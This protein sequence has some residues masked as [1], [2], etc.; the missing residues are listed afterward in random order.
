M[1]TPVLA[2]STAAAPTIPIAVA[3]ALAPD[4][5]NIEIDGRALQVP[6]GSM[7]IQAADKIGVQIPR[8]CYHDK[9]PIA[10]NCRMCLVEVE[11]A[12]KPMPACATPVM[13]G[14]KIHTQSERALSAQRN[15]MEFLLVNHP[16]DCPICDQGG[17]CELQDVAM[18][19]GRSVSRFTEDK[20]VVAD[21][22]LGP[23]I[24]TEMTRC[25]HCTRCVRFMD[26]IAGTNELGGMGRGETL[27]IGTYIGRS[28]RTELSGNII[29]VCPVGAL[30]NKVFRYRAR[31]WELVARA[32][33]G[34]HDS[35][36]SNLYLHTRRGEAMRA[37]PRDN[38]AINESWLSDRDRFSH[39]ALKH[40]ERAEKP[41]VKI[42]G[43]WRDADWAGAIS[44]VKDHLR[45]ITTLHGAD[46]LGVL[47]AGTASAE[48]YLLLNR[49]A[50]GLG[51]NNIDHRLR[52]LDFSDDAARSLAPTLSAPLADIEH[53]RAILLMGCNPRLDAPL[54]GHRV[55]KAWKRGGKVYAINPADFDFHFQVEQKLIGHAQN[56]VGYALA[57][58]KAAAEASAIAAPAE[59]AP[60]LAGALVSDNAR[61][62]VD[63]LKA[64]QPSRILFGEHAAQHPSAAILRACAQFVA[65]ATGAG[66]DEIPDSSNAAAAWRMGAV[67]HRSV[68]GAAIANPGLN[69]RQMI[70]QPRRAY[71]LC[72]AEIND[73]A[74]GNI[75]LEALAKADCV[76]VIG[77]FVNPTLETLAHVILPSAL[78]PETEGTY[79]NAEGIVQTV[80]A[81][82][83]APGDV[84]ACWRILRVLGA[85]MALPGF[86]F[87]DFA[88][89]HAELNAALA[90]NLAQPKACALSVPARSHERGLVLQALTSIYSTDAV[91]RR[92]AELQATV[93][94]AKPAVR[95]HPDDALGIGV[96]AGAAV[97]V[98]SA[99]L[100]VEIDRS[101]PKGGFLVT[102]GLDSTLDLPITGSV[103]Q[104]QKR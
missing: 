77:S 33:I 63:S 93:I 5:V 98:G 13:E 22:D 82:T 11:K 67:P 84:R 42:G 9:L 48:D 38:E 14:M 35:L 28:I 91:L 87:N 16:L 43:I 86:S 18:G 85:E 74:L 32:H 104:L 56:Q 79:V 96:S 19:Y 64:N 20:R 57:L 36:H 3:P 40:P 76:I 88:E 90:V 6:K 31:P 29:D 100:A 34:Y 26:E 70:E 60:L 1:S 53:A 71:I 24:A 65:S 47:V 37:V 39:V 2:A 27:E 62:I 101:V 61:V 103:V 52:Q 75:A 25:I 54:L 4:H 49:F 12:P 23:L 21:E 46:Q 94:A 58:A 69:A 83:K 59:L 73:F 92:S 89:L 55:R 97:T 95:L 102:A 68:G 45:E 44:F 15:V 66:F 17:E 8:F 78:P 7:I 81:A 72:A 80:Q 30:T 10:A 99:S 51:S 50:R 41:R